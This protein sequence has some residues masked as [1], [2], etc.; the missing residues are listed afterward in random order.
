V[1]QAAEAA[2]ARG[3]ERLDREHPDVRRT[4]PEKRIQGA[5]IVLQPKTG[6]ILAMVGG[7][8]Y[9]VSQFNRITQARRQPGSVFKPFTYLCALDRF[10]PASRISNDPTAIE[11]GGQEWLPRNSS[12]VPG[13]DISLRTALAH[14][15]N[16]P[17]VELAREMGLEAVV[18]TA[19][20][21]HFTTPLKPYPSLALGAFE[22]IPLELARAY[23]AF[24]ADGLLPTPLSLKDV[25]DENG[26]I[27]NRRNMKVEQVTTP[28]KAFIMNSLLNSVVKEGTARSLKSLGISQPVAAKTGTTNDYRDA[29][30]VGYTPDILAMV[31][32]GFDD[33]ASVKG[34]GASAALPIW[35]DLMRNIPQYLSGSW[36]RRPAGV[37]DRVVCAESGQLAVPGR[38]PETVQEVFLES[39]APTEP[40]PIHRPRNPFKKF[41]QEVDDFVHRL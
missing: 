22:V 24:A 5:I 25:G 11:A 6:Y 10:T 32:V 8:D 13:K 4:A 30:F 19:A 38:C 17:T 37:V 1:Q 12:I 21:F 29:W 40:C 34:T 39:L 31:W 15:V 33:G 7:R 35:A 20:A 28:A 16:I 2:L 3:L 14:S 27:L 9:N 26:K 23:C 18:R 36:F 41:F